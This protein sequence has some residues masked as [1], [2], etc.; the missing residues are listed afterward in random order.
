MPTDF[1]SLREFE[2]VN[3]NGAS[4]VY[5]LI[6]QV[7]TA[8]T[9]LENQTGSPS[10]G[11]GGP[12]ILSIAASTATRKTKY[13]YECTGTADEATFLTAIAALPASGGVIV[14]SEGTFNFST[15]LIITKPVIIRGVGPSTIINGSAIVAGGAVERGAIQWV[16]SRTQAVTTVTASILKGG[17]SFS[18]NNIPLF[19]RVTSSD[20]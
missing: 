19:P 5:E 14:L 16:G 2:V 13:D 20:W 6:N 4:A 1:N 15:E 7:Q 8:V 17:L 18:I 10:G 9:A 11:K 3:F 12:A